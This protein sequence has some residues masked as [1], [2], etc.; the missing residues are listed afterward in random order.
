MPVA[1][2]PQQYIDRILS[3]VGDADPWS[4]LSS[5]PSRLRQLV[6]GRTADDLSRKPAPGRWSV[7]EILAHLAD[8]ELVGGWRFR[9]ILASNAMTLQP[10]DQDRWAEVFKYETAPA[11]ESLDLFEMSRRGN[12]RLLRS[13]DPALLDNYGMHEERG[14]ESVAHLVR[15]YAGHDVNHL[16]QIE[17]LLGKSA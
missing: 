5:T 17:G 15:L 6:S 16:R 10:F 11:N 13:V 1:E 2:T 12:L 3:N 9:S 4:I 7:G 14:R 8:A